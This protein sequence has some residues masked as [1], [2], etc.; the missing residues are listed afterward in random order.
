M[1]VQPEH[2]RRTPPRGV[3]ANHR[4][5]ADPHQLFE[6]VFESAFLTLDLKIA[7]PDAGWHLYY[8]CLSSGIAIFPSQQAK[9][10]L[11]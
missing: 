2:H 11:D 9:A 4:R 1:F 3:P 7:K 8:A 6:A 10:A 5:T